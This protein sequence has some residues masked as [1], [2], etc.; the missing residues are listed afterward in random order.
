MTC[1]LCGLT[2]LRGSDDKL[3]RAAHARHLKLSKQ[4]WPR[5][6][7]DPYQSRQER[8]RWS[9]LREATQ[10]QNFHTNTPLRSSNTSGAATRSVLT[11]AFALRPAP[12]MPSK[13]LRS[14]KPSSPGPA[15]R[16]SIRRATD[17]RHAAQDRSKRSANRSGKAPIL[18]E[19]QAEA[20][21]GGAQCTL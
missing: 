7:I 20:V 11:L 4:Q 19:A 6:Q 3:H 5:G 13:G 1:D 21:P 2:Y 16:D 18:R 17:Q 15:V 14:P 12:V 10:S 8:Y 9:N